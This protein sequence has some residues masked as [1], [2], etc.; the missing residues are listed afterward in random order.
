MNANKKENETYIYRFPCYLKGDLNARFDGLTLQDGLRER[1][2]FENRHK[3]FLGKR[4]QTEEK[5]YEEKYTWF[6]NEKVLDLSEQIGS[7]LINQSLCPVN[8]DLKT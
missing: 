4:I 5:K 2:K 6:T 3:E 8:H 1:K 7:G